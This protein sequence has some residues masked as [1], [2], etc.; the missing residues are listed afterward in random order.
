MA[1]CRK[2]EEA[3]C[4]P[5]IMDPSLLAAFALVLLPL[6]LL[7]RSST[8][9]AAVHLIACALPAFIQ[10]KPTMVS[11]SDD[12]PQAELAELPDEEPKEP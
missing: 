3:S 12:I 8:P 1:P 7:P 6:T 2:P 4:Q 5:A 9:P 10:P 11:P